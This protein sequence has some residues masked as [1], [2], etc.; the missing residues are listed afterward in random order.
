MPNATLT[1]NIIHGWPFRDLLIVWVIQV[2]PD[3]NKVKEL[4]RPITSCRAPEV[5]AAVQLNPQES[6]RRVVVYSGV[7]QQS[8]L[9]ILKYHKLELFRRKT[10]YNS[11]R[12]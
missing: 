1:K 8:T 10:S 6:T 5:L 2:Q 3:K 4:A 9:R 11:V 12:F 7:S